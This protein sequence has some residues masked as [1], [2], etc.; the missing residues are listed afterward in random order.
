V[1]ALPAMLRNTRYAWTALAIM[2]NATKV[3]SSCI[4][5]ENVCAKIDGLSGS[6][7]TPASARKF[8]QIYRTV[9]RDKDISISR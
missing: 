4:G 8:A 2:A 3:A 6:L 1:F 9:D 7:E 5:E